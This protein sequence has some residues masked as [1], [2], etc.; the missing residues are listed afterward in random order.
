[1]QLDLLCSMNR[2]QT[3]LYYFQEPKLAWAFYHIWNDLSQYIWLQSHT[4]DRVLIM[5]MCSEGSVYD[6][7]CRPENAFGFSETLFIGFFNDLGTHLW[8]LTS[9]YIEQY[10]IIYQNWVTGPRKHWNCVVYYRAWKPILWC[11]WWPPSWISNFRLPSTC[12]VMN[13]W[14]QNMGRNCWNFVSILSKSQ[15]RPERVYP[16]P[17]PHPLEG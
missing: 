15:D 3:C 7:L 10:P 2:D 6:L 13:L 12:V 17:P 11:I 1:M 9:D 14:T 8:Y 5:E 16:S 4:K